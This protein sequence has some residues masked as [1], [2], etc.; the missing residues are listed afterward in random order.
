MNEIAYKILKHQTPHI[1]TYHL[2]YHQS[3]KVVFDHQDTNPS[4]IYFKWI[5]LGQYRWRVFILPCTYMDHENNDDDDDPHEGH[6]HNLSIHLQY[7][8]DDDET[9]HRLEVC[10]NIEIAQD[11]LSAIYVWPFHHEFKSTN[12]THECGLI[13]P[14]HPLYP[15][16][17]SNV[18]K[19]PFTFNL[20]LTL[21]KQ[22]ICDDGTFI[23]PI[24]HVEF[25]NNILL[26]KH[27]DYT[28]ITMKDTLFHVCNDVLK[29]R[30]I[31]LLEQTTQSLIDQANITPSSLNV[32]IAYIH[33]T[34]IVYNTHDIIVLLNLKWLCLVCRAPTHHVDDVLENAWLHLVSGHFVVESWM[35]PLIHAY[36]L[37]DI[38]SPF[39]P[40]FQHM[41]NTFH[42]ES[43]DYYRKILPVISY[44]LKTHQA[45]HLIPWINLSL[46]TRENQNL[47][48]D[49]PLM[50]TKQTTSC[51]TEPWWTLLA[52]H[53]LPRLS[54]S[55]DHHKLDDLPLIEPDFTLCTHDGQACYRVHH[56][57]LYGQW[58]FFKHMSDFGGC[59]VTQSTWILPPHWSPRRLKEFLIYMYT[60]KVLFDDED[61]VWWLLQHAELY[62]WVNL[63]QMPTMGFEKLIKYCIQKLYAPLDI[64]NCVH[65]YNIAVCIGMEERVRECESFCKKRHIA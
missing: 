16:Q 53:T 1:R 65:M 22:S 12:A 32:F 62:H 54:N 45:S 24:A 34:P 4:F 40:S 36:H 5:R 59:E 60:Q 31:S 11:D 28:Q 29:I 64:H 2:P 35:A 39:F 33:N 15:L 55:I 63:K 43:A 38:Y 41:I 47:T 48:V 23:P 46:E 6:H 30:G 27:L 8:Q 25:P 61:D 58:R 51:D 20:H 56:W 14:D 21:F 9:Y 52:F 49:Q 37:Q 7:I 50:I 26:G 19:I 18:I 13:T 44:Y 3:F 10:G 42:V 17:Q 57:F